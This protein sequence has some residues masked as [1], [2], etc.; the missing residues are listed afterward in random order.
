MKFP[1]QTSTLIKSYLESRTIQVKINT[2]SKEQEIRAGVPQVF[3]LSALLYLI[4]VAD[5]SKTSNTKLAMFAD[6][7]AIATKTIV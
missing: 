2:T 6:D 4:Y 5:I 7:T 3:V 1:L